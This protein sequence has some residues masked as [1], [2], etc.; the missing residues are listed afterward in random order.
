MGLDLNTLARTV[1]G[2][3]AANDVLRAPFPAT[4]GTYQRYEFTV[5]GLDGDDKLFGS[6][7]P[8]NWARLRH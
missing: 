4:N 3:D 6:R 8:W 2:S 1:N 5:N 7:G